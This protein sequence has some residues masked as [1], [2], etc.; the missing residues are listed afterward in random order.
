MM[1]V[2]STAH[3]RALRRIEVTDAFGALLGVD[4]EHAILFGN[5]HVRTFGFTG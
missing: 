2:L 5:G 3:R 4:D 1:Q